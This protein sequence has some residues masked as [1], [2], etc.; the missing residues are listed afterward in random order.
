[1]PHHGTTE[2]ILP[3]HGTTE[4]ILPITEPRRSRDFDRNVGGFFDVILLFNF[5]RSLRDH[6]TAIFEAINNFIRPDVVCVFS[7]IAK[8]ILGFIHKRRSPKIAK[9]YPLPC[10]QNVRTG[11]ISPCPC[12]H[13]ID[14]E[15][16]EVFAPKSA[17]PSLPCPQNVRTEQIPSP[18]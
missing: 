14:F 5:C 12:G 1:L 8:S 4:K 18:P 17:F 16:S 13:T 10:P 6:K 15:K 3:H 11:S 2:K 7:R 9:N